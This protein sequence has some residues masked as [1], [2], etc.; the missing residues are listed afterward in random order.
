MFSNIIKKVE[1]D[2]DGKLNEYELLRAIRIAQASESEA[3]HIYGQIREA[4]KDKIV[5][6]IM[7]HIIEDEAKHSGELMG[8][9]HYIFPEE[10]KLYDQGMKEFVEAVGEVST[11]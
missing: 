9:I 4:T 8:L 6:K 7:S 2:E 3:I 1:V 11:A 5:K 10:Q